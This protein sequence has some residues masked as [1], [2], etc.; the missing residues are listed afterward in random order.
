M[1]SL[2]LLIIWA[3]SVTVIVSE[4]RKKSNQGLN[5]CYLDTAFVNSSKGWKYCD[6]SKIT[7]ASDRDVVVSPVKTLSPSNAHDTL[8]INPRTHTSSG[9][10]GHSHRGPHRL[11]QLDLSSDVE[12]S[13]SQG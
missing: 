5:L 7:P 8:R 13:C 9:T 11:L 4:Q 3:A 12:K 2:L 10:S 1:I 6:D